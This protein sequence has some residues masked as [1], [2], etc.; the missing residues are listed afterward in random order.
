MTIFPNFI[1]NLLALMLPWLIEK[2][3][4]TRLSVNATKKGS[5][6]WITAF[7]MRRCR[8]A[9]LNL[10]AENHKSF[11]MSDNNFFSTSRVISP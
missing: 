2:L 5:G 1:A 10:R 3:R 9:C 6:L 11:L 8:N 7:Y 4:V